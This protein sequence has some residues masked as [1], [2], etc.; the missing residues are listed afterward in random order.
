M[1]KKSTHVSLTPTFVTGY[2]LQMVSLY[3]SSSEPLPSL[4]AH[5][6][7]NFIQPWSHI[8]PNTNLKSS[9]CRWAGPG[10]GSCNTAKSSGEWELWSRKVVEGRK[11]GG[12]GEAVRRKQARW[13]QSTGGRAKCSKPV[14]EPFTSLPACA[15]DPTARRCVG[16]TEQ[17]RV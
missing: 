12:W 9:T 16:S 13:R 14:E 11:P 7:G 5:R 8:W 3:L 6:H 10:K 4:C 15:L 1:L 17:T 2:S